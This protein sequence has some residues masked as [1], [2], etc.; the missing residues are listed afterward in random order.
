[1]KDFVGENDD[2]SCVIEIRRKE[3]VFENSK[4]KPQ[5]H[6]ITA[7]NHQRPVLSPQQVTRRKKRSLEESKE[8][9]FENSAEKPETPVTANKI[10]RPVGAK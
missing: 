1:V 10:Q 4:K 9:V 8:F 3:V 5:P 6:P 7:N 2:L